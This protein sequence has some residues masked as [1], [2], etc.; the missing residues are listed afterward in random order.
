MS[1]MHIY[2]PIFDALA[3]RKTQLTCCKLCNCRGTTQYRA[4]VGTHTDD[5]IRNLLLDHKAAKGQKKDLFPCFRH[6]GYTEELF[7]H[8]D[9]E[10]SFRRPHDTE[11]T[12]IEGLS[13]TEMRVCDD[14]D[15]QAIT[16]L[17]QHWPELAPLF[18]Q[19]VT[20]IYGSGL[21]RIA[22]VQ[23]SLEDDFRSLPDELSMLSELA[24]QTTLYTFVNNIIAHGAKFQSSEFYFL[25]KTPTV[26]LLLRTKA[27]GY[28][29]SSTLFTRPTPADAW[30]DQYEGEADDPEAYHAICAE[31]YS[32]F[33][34]LQQME[35]D[36]QTFAH[37]LAPSGM[38]HVGLDRIVNKTGF[39]VRFF[40][41]Y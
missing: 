24:D 23:R 1:I 41:G 8:T 19:H 21:R 11:A 39:P 38:Y 35:G 4:I 31:F 37:P 9:P 34:S 26:C 13:P 27:D 32:L 29:V 2:S 14:A 12:R 28:C 33:V 10:N 7:Y 25:H 30:V 20:V 3:E 15:I 22:D 6:C 17:R 18:S 16:Y 5:E 40:S 36:F